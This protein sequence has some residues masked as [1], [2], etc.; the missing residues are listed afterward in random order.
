M[1]ILDGN[2]YVRD[3]MCL[4]LF[5]GVYEGGRKNLELCVIYLLCLLRQCKYL[6]AVF[7]SYW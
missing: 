4:S 6:T 1:S 2:Y 3:K 5:C 7:I